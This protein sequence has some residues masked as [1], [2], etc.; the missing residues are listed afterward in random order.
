MFTF[1]H[2]KKVLKVKVKSVGLSE[3]LVRISQK[4]GSYYFCL[5]N[6]WLRILYKVHL[7][8][9]CASVRQ[10]QS[11]RQCNEGF[12]FH[13]LVQKRKKCRTHTHTNLHDDK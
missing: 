6:K 10:F 7:S 13:L 2:A 1:L 5:R 3:R 9:L 11:E 4:Y 12:I 8:I